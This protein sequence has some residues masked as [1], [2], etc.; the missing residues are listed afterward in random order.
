ME[1]QYSDHLLVRLK[2]RGIPQ[3]LPRIVYQKAERRFYDTQSELE[4][5]VLQTKYFGKSR[6]IMVAYRSH[7]NHVLLITIHP[8]KVNQLENRIE[9]GRWEEIS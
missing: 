1:I 2:M 9:S 3:E 5:A 8:L 4:I 6:P 7:P